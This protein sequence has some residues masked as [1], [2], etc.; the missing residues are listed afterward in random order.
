M[1][2]GDLVILCENGDPQKVI[3]NKNDFGIILNT[4]A[5]RARDATS[6]YWIKQ[7]RTDWVPTKNL[8]KINE[9]R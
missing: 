8:K 6:V 9:D 4:R 5:P 2:I 1:K 7:E 3:F